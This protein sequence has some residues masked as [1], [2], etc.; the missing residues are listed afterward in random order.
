MN[1]NSIEYHEVKGWMDERSKLKIE[2]M[3]T[4]NPDKKLLV[5]QGDWFGKNNKIFA[6]KIKDWE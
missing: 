3:K 2:G 5:I 1:D 6:D 4:S